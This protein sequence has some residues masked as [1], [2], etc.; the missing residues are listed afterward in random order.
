MSG[1]PDHG[2]HLDEGSADSFPASDVPKT[3][4]QAGVMADD[5]PINAA[6]AVSSTVRRML[7]TGL[8]ALHRAQLGMNEL[9]VALQDGSGALGEF[10]GMR[11]AAS[12]SQAQRIDSVLTHFG[13]ARPDSHAGHLAPAGGI[14]SVY[15]Q[16]TEGPVRDL[17]GAY[18]LHTA[19]QQEVGAYQGL[20]ILARKVDAPH[21]IEILKECQ[22]EASST[23]D[24][25][26]TLIEDRLLPEA[27]AALNA[28]L[29]KELIELAFGG[30]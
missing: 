27:S 25:L 23:A 8:V 18:A 30:A 10:T 29:P 3:V 5:A 2:K 12:V 1:G 4:E 14:A 16:T 26:R 7:M 20:E 28:E 13:H 21:T 17:A 9:L 24:E 15:R 22:A 11:A 19:I 6:P